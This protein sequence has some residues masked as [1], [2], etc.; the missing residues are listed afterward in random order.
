MKNVTRIILGTWLG[1]IST[2]YAFQVGVVLDRAG[3]D[4]KSFNAA[5]FNGSEKAKKELGIVVKVIEPR[6]IS[7]YEPSLEELAKRGF[8]LV[9]GIGF[10]HKEAI[11][12]VSKKYPKINF[13]I[14]DAK[15]DAPNVASLMFEEQEGSFLIGM[16]AALKSKTHVIGFVGGMDIPLIRR[17]DLAYKAGAEFADPKIKVIKNYVGVTNE[18]FTD[19]TKAKELTSAQIAQQADVIFH[20]AGT[21]GL[22]VFEAAESGK[23]FAIGVDS[24]QNWIKPGTILTSMLKR[25][26][27]AVFD[28]I[29]ATKEG[30]FKS[31]IHT[32]NLKNKGID[33]AVDEHNTKLLDK[34]IIAK[35]EDAKTKIIAGKINVPD[36]YKEK[37]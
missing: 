34:V 31:G 32:F 1:F 9:I 22:G 8:D 2:T 24:N 13:A 6:D 17:F 19:P 27:V 20:A 7:S 28:L 26:D 21:S 23:V 33:Y 10:T 25:I 11:E 5:A 12:K 16:A 35:L 37:K 4:D 14:V 36:Y 18:A 29:K 15:V 3:K 30:K